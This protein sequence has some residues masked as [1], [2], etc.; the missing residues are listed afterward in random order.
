MKKDAIPSGHLPLCPCV[1][2]PS[3]CMPLSHLL[4]RGRMFPASPCSVS[5]QP[6]PGYIVLTLQRTRGAR[7]TVGGTGPMVPGC[8]W[9]PSSALLPKTPSHSPLNREPGQA[10]PPPS[11]FSSEPNLASHK[12]QPFS[13][14][15]LTVLR[16]ACTALRMVP[17]VPEKEQSEKGAHLPASPLQA[18]GPLIPS[19][20]GVMPCMGYECFRTQHTE[21]Q[22]TQQGAQAP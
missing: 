9:A 1:P 13:D 22:L 5:T 12:R 3:G 18:P 15:A 6:S 20:E 14:R 17:I 2:L 4:G 21:E 16:G 7:R 8:T 10:S 19:E 11:S